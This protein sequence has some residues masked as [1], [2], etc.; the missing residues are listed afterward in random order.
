M[1]CYLSDRCCG[2]RL[3]YKE[4]VDNQ[5]DLAS[6]TVMPG[7]TGCLQL[8]CSHL[9]LGRSLLQLSKRPALLLH[10]SGACMPCLTF[11]SPKESMEVSLSEVR[12]SRSGEL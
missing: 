4:G 2:L 12:N 11:S 3:L 6:H 10:F 5:G 7:N 8:L 9:L 1:L